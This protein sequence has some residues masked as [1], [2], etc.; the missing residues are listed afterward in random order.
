MSVTTLFVYIIITVQ[1]DTSD[2]VGNQSMTSL[3]QPE[4]WVLKG[5]NNK[6][7]KGN[8]FIKP[9]TQAGAHLVS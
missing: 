8:Q 5:I 3:L 6:K 4:P 9:G 2:F 7:Y 1:Y